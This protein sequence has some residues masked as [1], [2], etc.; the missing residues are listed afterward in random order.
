[1]VE[2]CVF[3]LRIFI[4]KFI[5]WATQHASYEFDLKYFSLEFSTEDPCV[6]FLNI[7]FFEMYKIKKP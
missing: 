3:I 2:I 4:I 5:P 6:I 7:K 1:M